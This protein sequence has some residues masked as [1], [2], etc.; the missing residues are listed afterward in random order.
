MGASENRRFHFE[1]NENTD[2]STTERDSGDSH[3][4]VFS[5]I[6]TCATR[7]LPAVLTSF[8]AAALGL[9]DEAAFPET[10]LHLGGDII[11]CDIFVSRHHKSM[12]QKV[13]YLIDQVISVRFE[14]GFSHLCGLFE[15]LLFIFAVPLCMSLATYDFSISSPLRCSMTSKSR[16]KIVPFIDT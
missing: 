4:I 14:R 5:N 15:Y 7:H 1:T 10:A 11:E 2:F 3:L 9:L 12:K 16:S 6:A 13:A 8:I